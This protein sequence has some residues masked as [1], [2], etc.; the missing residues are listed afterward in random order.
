MEQPLFK[1]LNPP[2]SSFPFPPHRRRHLKSETFCTLVR[3]LSHC[4]PEPQHPHSNRDSSKKKPGQVTEPELRGEPL[5]QIGLESETLS[6]Q[7][8]AQSLKGVCVDECFDE[9]KME[10]IGSDIVE[11][12]NNEH[13]QEN[14]IKCGNSLEDKYPSGNVGSVTGDR[15][16]QCNVHE[17]STEKS[18]NERQ[19]VANKDHHNFEVEA[20]DMS[21]DIDTMHK[22]LELDEHNEEGST[23]AE[24][25]ELEEVKHEMQFMGFE[26][27]VA[28]CGT[29]NSPLCVTV[30]EEIEEGEI[31]GNFGPVDQSTDLLLEEV[32]L[33]KEKVDE[34]LNSEAIINEEPFKEQKGASQEGSTFNNNFVETIDTVCNGAELKLG[35][36]NMSEMEC[37]SKMVVCGKSEGAKTAPDYNSEL[38]IGRNKNRASRA[39]EEFN[40]PTIPEISG[41]NATENPCTLS[42][43]EDGGIHKKGKRGHLTKERKAKKKLKERIKRA[44]KNKRLGIKRLKIQPVLKPKTVTYCRHYL[45]GR[46]QEGEKCK[47]S[48]DTIPLTK[49]KMPPMEGSPSTANVSKPEMKPSSLLM[50]TD[51]EKQLNLHSSSYQKFDSK[52]GTKMIPPSNNTEQN[53][54]EAILR[55]ALQTPKGI[56]KLMFGK[57]SLGNPSK[58][59]QASPYPKADGGVKIGLPI[60]HDTPYM[61]QNLNEISKIT[62]EPKGIHFLSFGKA[63]LHDSSSKDPFSLPFWRDRISQKSSLGGSSKDKQAALSPKDGDIVQFGNQTGQSTTTDMVHSSEIPERTP[64]V[65]PRGINF[66]SFGKTPL[67]ES[68]TM[69]V[70]TSPFN[71]VGSSVQETVSASKLQ[72]PSAKPWRMLS[73]SLHPDQSLD[74]LENEHLKDK[75]SSALKALLFNTANLAHQEG[76]LLSNMPESAKKTLQSTLAF[77][78]NYESRIK[79]DAHSTVGADSNK[80]S[81]SSKN[82]SRGS[83][84]LDFLYS[85]TSKSKTKQ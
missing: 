43:K 71:G 2:D 54:A 78:A 63:P 25:Y 77:A 22:F 7:R 69:K 83:T 32:S 57:S 66:L 34:E 44:E 52:S 82:T 15:E 29:M 21:I 23:F 74:R 55:P 19:V 56:S 67:G 61:A 84:I 51:S 11:S 13:I 48:H 68:S 35:E 65:A 14:G 58:L 3:I 64:A 38:E 76:P 17:I 41:A 16:G 18:G 60:S 50:Y 5:C 1:T 37:N 73:S 6:I 85:D 40:H 46:C 30:D 26:K 24:R 47:F 53:G 4:Y 39:I 12:T 79:M 72:I 75:S 8:D 20:L 31:S 42:T 70:A 45:K 59:N 80:Q 9:D 10:I 62:A 81:S 36:R 33:E 27:S 49:S 28:N